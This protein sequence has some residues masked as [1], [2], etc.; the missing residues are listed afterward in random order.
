MSLAP[1][2]GDTG[3]SWK[4]KTSVRKKIPS[5]NTSMQKP[6]VAGKHSS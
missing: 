6:G 2:I 4:N 5:A 1:V 3:G